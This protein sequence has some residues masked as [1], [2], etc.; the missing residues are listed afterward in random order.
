MDGDFWVFAYGSLIWKP[1]FAYQEMIPATLFGWHRALCILS[2]HY[3]GCPDAPG[4][5]LGLD[6]GGSCRGVAYRVAAAEALSVRRYLDERELITDVYIPRF[7]DLRLA[8]G[9]RIPAYVYTARRG[10]RQYAGRLPLDEVCRLVRRGIGHAGSSRDYL[11]ATVS[12]LD[13][14]GLADTGL[15]RLLAL[16]DDHAGQA[17]R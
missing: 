6:R 14:I 17:V 5:V 12:H 3:R 1:G 11:A 10:H 13:A 7:L 8:D 16:V 15:R 9:R 2:T 4:L